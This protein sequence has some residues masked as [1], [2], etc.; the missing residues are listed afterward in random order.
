MKTKDIIFT[1]EAIKDD[2]RY[3]QLLS[4]SYPTIADA[5]TEIIN[6]E[7]ILNL[8]KPTE[9]FISD[10]HGESDAFNHVLRNASGYV[11]RKVK[12]ILGE[13][14]TK[15]ESQELCT[16]IY[17][18]EQK[19]QFIKAKAHGRDMTDFY[20]TTLH[21]LILVCRE[22]SSKYT[23]S[24]IRKALP[25]QFDYIIPVEERIP[26]RSCN[27]GERCI[28]VSPEGE[29]RY[30]SVEEGLD[31]WGK[32]LGT[33]VRCTDALAGAVISAA[34]GETLLVPERYFR[35][36]HKGFLEMQKAVLK[37]TVHL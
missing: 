1:E 11:K 6:L 34:P 14:L 31:I 4:Q 15:K 3:L 27:S 13:T 18:P 2:M 8:P 7:A 32:T 37:N 24:K 30:T 12:E 10:P 36:Q 17:Y 16:L 19:L 35:E 26:E 20:L 5:S 33:D 28:W 23:R 29:V 9:H 25:A 21:Q 22:V